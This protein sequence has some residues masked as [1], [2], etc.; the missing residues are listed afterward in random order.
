M[1]GKYFKTK[2]GKR[3]QLKTTVGWAFQIKWKN[4]TK[5]WVNLKDFKESN[6]VDVAEYVT[7]R[8]IQDEPAFAWWV[9]YTLQKRDVI[10]SAVSSRV[11]KCSHKYGIEIP[12]SIT[13]AKWIDRKNGNNFWTDAILKEM[14]NVGITFTILDLGKKAPQGC[15]KASGHLEFD[16]D[17]DFMRKA[18]WFKDG[19]R[20]P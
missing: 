12:T 18:R 19:H 13:H 14:N 17:M 6:P 7:A 16:V 9:P 1:S 4:G 3:T 5:Q 8:G 11:R 10:V 15:T 2:Q 20:S